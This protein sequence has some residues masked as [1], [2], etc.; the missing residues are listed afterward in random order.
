MHLPGCR[1]RTTV[2]CGLL[3]HSQVQVTGQLWESD[4]LCRK[5]GKLGSRSPAFCNIFFQKFNSVFSVWTT[6]PSR[7][8][9]PDIVPCGSNCVE[10]PYSNIFRSASRTLNKYPISFQALSNLCEDCK[11]VESSVNVRPKWQLGKG[12]GQCGR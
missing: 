6:T 3:D 12:R 8:G 10:M 9:C 7:Q 5:L 4:W 2:C 11:T 1:L